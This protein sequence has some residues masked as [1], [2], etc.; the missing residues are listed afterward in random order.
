MAVDHR[1]SEAYRVSRKNPER[2]DTMLRDVAI[3]ATRN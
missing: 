1:L 2:T 3:E